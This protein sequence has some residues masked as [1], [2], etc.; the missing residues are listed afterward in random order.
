M[1]EIYP[2]R[3]IRNSYL[4][5]R[6]MSLKKDLPGQAR[7][8]RG[9]LVRLYVPILLLFLGVAGLA[10]LIPALTIHELV[11]DVNSITE[12]PFYVGAI[13][14]LGM[15]LWAA[16][17]AICLWSAAYLGRAGASPA[18]RYVLFAGLLTLALLLDDL[19]LIH[20][21]VMPEYLGIPEKVFLAGYLVAIVA[22]LYTNRAEILGSEYLLLGL[23]LALFGASVFLDAIPNRFYDSVY[24]MP[25]LE[26]LFEDG[27]KF[28]GIATWLVYFGRYSAQQV[29]RLDR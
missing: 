20:E 27:F 4:W 29:A 3:M 2:A 28:A 19:F 11:T 9:L 7:A 10:Y 5:E 17:A 13:S 12:M 25:K 15:L 22:F 1:G 23:A 6:V 18:R 16:A 21:E 14:Q 8:L 26:K 24:W